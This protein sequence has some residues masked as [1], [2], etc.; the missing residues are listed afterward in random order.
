[1]LSRVRNDY[2]HYD[3]PRPSGQPWNLRLSRLGAR[4]ARLRTEPLHA[5]VGDYR[6]VG[7]AQCLVRWPEGPHPRLRPSV[8]P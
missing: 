1:V 6:L 2:S 5:V 8:E 4:S 3:G 7:A